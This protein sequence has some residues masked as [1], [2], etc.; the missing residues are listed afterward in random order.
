MHRVTKHSHGVTVLVLV[1]SDPRVQ[2]NNKYQIKPK[3]PALP[4]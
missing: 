4:C 1:Q 2:K 3:N